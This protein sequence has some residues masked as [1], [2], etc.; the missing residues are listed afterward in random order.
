M[1]RIEVRLSGF[2]GQGIVSAAHILGK[3]ASLYDRKFAS[4]KPSY[5]PESR[6]GACAADIIIDD[7]PISYPRLVRPD[8]LV[9][10]SQP[11]FAKYGPN[12]APDGVLITET[13][14]VTVDGQCPAA[15]QLTISAARLADSLGKRIVANMV[16]LGFVAATCSVVT[17]QALREA[18]AVSVPRGTEEL[19]LKAFELG[20]AQAGG[21]G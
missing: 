1:S 7:E 5:G 3:A 18:I 15:R 2:G 6:G 17:S 13:E 20:M 4:L 11:A 21:G 16:V 19:N 14:L 9:A 10:L 12:V 8:I